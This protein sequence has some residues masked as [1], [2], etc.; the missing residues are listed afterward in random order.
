MSVG[1]KERSAKL[2]LG[3]SMDVFAAKA[4]GIPP[5]LKGFTV[6]PLSTADSALEKLTLSKVK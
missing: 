1:N 4:N 5:L 2:S 6:V 3:L